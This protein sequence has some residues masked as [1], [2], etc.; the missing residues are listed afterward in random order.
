M[1]MLLIEAMKSPVWTRVDASS[2]RSVT[3]SHR[4]DIELGLRSF[5]SAA[6]TGIETQERGGANAT[7]APS[8]DQIGHVAEP[9]DMSVSGQDLEIQTIS[10]AADGIEDVALPHHTSASMQDLEIQPIPSTADGTG[11]VALPHHTSASMQDPVFQ[12]IPSME[13]G[14]EGVAEAHHTFVSMQ[15]SK[16]QPI[17]S[18][19]AGT[20]DVAWP[21]HT[22]ASMQDPEPQIQSRATIDPKEAPDPSLVQEAPLNSDIFPKIDPDETQPAL[23]DTEHLSLQMTA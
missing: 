1:R 2:S 17:P 3:D 14:I 8:V 7:S 5:P 20:V 9:N 4:T 16:L 10:S 6:A 21:D 13:D 11:D 12:T 22:P 23:T 19:T 15:D 18:T